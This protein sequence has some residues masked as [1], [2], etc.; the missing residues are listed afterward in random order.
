LGSVFSAPLDDYV[1]APDPTYHWNLTTKIS[2]TGFTIYNIALTSQTWLTAA[3]SS[4]PIWQH[5]LQ[6]CI[7][8]VIFTDIAFMYIDGGH[9]P[10]FNNPPT[11]A[12]N[13]FIGPLCGI[14][15]AVTV[16]LSA[17]PDEPITFPADP[18]H[19][20][21]TEDAIIAFTWAIFL[22]NTNVNP[23]WLLRFPMTKAAVNAMTTVQDFVR[24]ERSRGIVGF[25]VGGASKRGWTTWT[26][27]AVDRRVLAIVP[28]VAP[29]LN[30]TGIMNRMW[31]AYGTWSFALDDYSQEN[32]PAF[33]N[34]PQFADLLDLVGPSAFVDRLTMPKFVICATG[35][36][37]FMPESAEFFWQYLMG[38]KYLKMLPNA[39]HSLA[40]HEID[41]VLNVQQFFEAFIQSRELP[42]L[43]WEFSNN[44]STIT[45]MLSQQP[46]NVQLWEAY[47][48][49]ARDFRLVVCGK[50]NSTC[51][52]PILWAPKDLNVTSMGDGTYMATATMNVPE[53]G[54]RGGMVEASFEL[55]RISGRLDPFKLT[56]AVTIVPLTLPYPPC[57][58][59]VC[60]CGNS[61]Q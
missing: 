35:D 53:K 25:V 58:S 13:P 45:V 23:E 20:S 48:P 29:V 18:K 36:E 8:D 43:D 30:L 14:T 57:P 59:N 61:C 31:H 4:Q 3:N 40:G 47:N 11:S 46:K 60:A 38:P 9:T 16:E 21:R 6:V 27:G 49:K 28:L 12:L 54:W 42:T 33:I 37:F 56:S 44:G 52:N 10:D 7:P 39:E 22:N 17:I 32:V 19:Q 2:G 55:T 51:V 34:L 15:Q 24:Q 5:W 41:I 26:T 50:A 1:F